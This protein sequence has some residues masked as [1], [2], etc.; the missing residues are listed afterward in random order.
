VIAALALG[1]RTVRYPGSYL[2]AYRRG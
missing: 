2:K 1:G